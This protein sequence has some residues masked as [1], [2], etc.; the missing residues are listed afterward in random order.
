MNITLS[1]QA[2]DWFENHFPL[3]EGEAVRFFGK[4]YG[5]TEVHEG[6]S[7]GLELDDPKQSDDILAST[8]VNNR[9]YFINREDEWFFSGF[10][11]NIE[12]DQQFGEPSYHFESREWLSIA[13]KHYFYK[14]SNLEMIMG[15]MLFY[16]LV[17]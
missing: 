10:N 5:K 8:E 7:I 9:T 2:A 17:S 4:T 1:E 6:F 15:I 11:L 16:V 14:I 3:D 13:K 12:L